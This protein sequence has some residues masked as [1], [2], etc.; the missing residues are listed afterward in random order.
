MYLYMTERYSSAHPLAD[1]YSKIFQ[2]LLLPFL[3]LSFSHFTVAQGHYNGGSFNPNDYFTAPPGFIIPAYYGYANMD[4]YNADGEKTDQLIN[5]VPGN[6]TSVNLEQNV[7]TNSFI[8]M[9]IYGG[10]GK[11][12]NAD[13]GMM[14]IPM[15]N[16]PT[17]NI[18]LDYYTSET[19]SGN[20]S[21]KS[22]S[23]GLGDLYLQPIWLTWNRDKWSYSFTYGVWAPLG[24]YEAGDPENVGLGYWSHNFRA[25]TKF[26]AAP[27][28]LI[29]LATTYEI[30]AKQEGVDF[31]EA[32][33]FT[34]DYGLSYTLLK[35]HEFGLFGF[36]TTQT[37][38]DNG[39]E[40][41]FLSDQYAGLGAYGSYWIKPGKYGVLARVT[42]H[43]GTTNRFAGTTFQIGFNTLF[44]K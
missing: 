7:K 33:H 35:G 8:L 21:F 39:T 11:I 19:G 36:Y 17:A 42:Q 9:L 44:L 31:E 27:Q 20:V 12:L 1:K 5:P 40:G 13:W 25:A 16:N 15:V 10:K 4:F 43:F 3:V 29:S 30:N 41:S 14:L 2:I 22:N 26:R 32:P 6:P 37:G 28:W 23:W 24:K 18:A 34:L 38:E